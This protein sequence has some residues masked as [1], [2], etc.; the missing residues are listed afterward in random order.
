MEL[1]INN[2]IVKRVGQFKIKSRH[3]TVGRIYLP[4]RFVGRKVAITLLDEE[5]DTETNESTV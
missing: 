5:E 1:A 4:S 2:T 3:Q